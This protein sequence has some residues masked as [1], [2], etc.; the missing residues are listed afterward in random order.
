MESQ[1][2]AP[3]VTT[4]RKEPPTTSPILAH[5]EPTIQREEPATSPCVLH[6]PPESTALVGVR[7]G[8]KATARLDTTAPP[9]AKTL[10]A[11]TSL[12]EE[13]VLTRPRTTRSPTLMV[14]SALEDTPARKVP[15]PQQCVYQEH[16]HP[17][18]EC[19]R[20]FNALPAVGA[21]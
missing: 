8:L 19:L 1:E 3:R 7:N 4:A 12:A 21:E 11:A 14:V 17:I 18:L 16:T 6:A 5:L 13:T 20:V 15:V 2:S 10:V 9:D